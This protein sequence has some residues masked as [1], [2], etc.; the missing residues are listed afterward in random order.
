MAG[1]PT[2]TEATFQF[3][4]VNDEYVVVFPGPVD[5]FTLDKVSFYISAVGSAPSAGNLTVAVYAVSTTT[6]APTGAALAS[7]NVDATT[8]T[9]AGRYVASGLAL[10]LTATTLYALSIKADAS[11][12]GDVTQR[13]SSAS[14]GGSIPYALTNNAGGGYNKVQSGAGGF[15]IGLGTTTD[16]KK[17]AGLNGALVTVDTTLNV[18]DAGNPDEV[19]NTFTFSQPLRIIGGVCYS[20]AGAG[21]AL[22]ILRDSGGTSQRSVTFDQDQ[23]SASTD[24]G[25]QY[26]FSSAYDVAASTAFDMTL[27]KQ[28]QAGT[29]AI[30]YLETADNAEMAAMWN[31]SM[32]GVTYNNGGSRGTQTARL[33]GVFPLISH[34]GD[35]AGG[36]GGIGALVGGSLAGR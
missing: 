13:T 15:Y 29:A 2:G 8:I 34:I 23:L 20:T 12:V 35:D 22:T 4:A 10:A 19:G 14:T 24:R 25:L 21:P 17:V 33:Y 30:Q 5:A 31:L 6:G 1:Y 3:N 9:A 11:Y 28:G 26:Y 36:G 16:Y 27:S 7:V 18:S 32:Y